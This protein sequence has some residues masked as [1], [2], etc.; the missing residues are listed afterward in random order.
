MDITAFDNPEIFPADSIILKYL[1]KNASYWNTLF[2]NIASNF[3]DLSGSWKYYKDGKMWLY[4]CS[5]STKTVFWLALIDNSFRIT[6][7]FNANNEHFLYDSPIPD[8]IKEYYREN[9][10][11]KKNKNV[12][13]LVKNKKDID[14]II[15]LIK[16]KSLC[17]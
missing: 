15:V 9:T 10:I 2:E 13:I 5:K 6:F 11:N 16:T 17:L 7:Y 1:G 3:K 4:K 14:D 8:K 12:T